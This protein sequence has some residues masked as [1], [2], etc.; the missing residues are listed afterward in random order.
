VL[1]SPSNP[2]KE[3]VT[4]AAPARPAGGSQGLCVRSGSYALSKQLITFH[5]RMQSP[6]RRPRHLYVHGPTSHAAL[7]SRSLQQVRTVPDRSHR[8]N[9][10][11][12]P[13]NGSGCRP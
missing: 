7:R 5:V 9:L 10:Q 11:Q 13:A 6:L 3:A 1:R 4:T 12:R 2:T 8:I